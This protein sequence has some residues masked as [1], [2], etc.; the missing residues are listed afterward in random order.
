MRIGAVREIEKR[1]HDA[2]HNHRRAI[3]VDGA[4]DHRGVRLEPT[5]PQR[6]TENRGLAPA[7]LFV[8][9]G[10]PAPERG[11]HT[12]YREIARGH[13]GR[14]HLL[15]LSAA[16]QRERARVV[17]RHLVECPAALADMGK[18]TLREV[19]LAELLG[20]GGEPERH[21]ASRSGQ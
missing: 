14:V 19:H 15:G 9:A 11:V 1:R 16:R 4:P 10:E 6:L 18:E 2:D 12:Q 17:G 8:L 13:F 21:Q 7:W 20:R 5:P 3:E